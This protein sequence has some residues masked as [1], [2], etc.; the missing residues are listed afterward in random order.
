MKTLS[1]LSVLARNYLTRKAVAES[2]LCSHGSL[3]G[4]VK[5]FTTRRARNTI[6]HSDDV[7]YDDDWSKFNEWGQKLNPHYIFDLEKDE[8][9]RQVSIGLDALLWP[10]T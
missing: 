2:A 9:N 5:D 4:S 8:E 1:A 6:K 7:N 3:T 10:K